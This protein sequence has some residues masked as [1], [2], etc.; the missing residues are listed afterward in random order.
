MNTTWCCVGKNKIDGYWVLQH[1]ATGAQCRVDGR[2]DYLP[3]LQLLNREERIGDIKDELDRTTFCLKRATTTINHWE[4]IHRD[5]MAETFKLIEALEVTKAIEEGT[6]SMDAMLNRIEELKTENKELK[7]AVIEKTFDGVTKKTGNS[8]IR[9]AICVAH[10]LAERNKQDEKWGEQNHDPVYWSAILTEECGEYAEAA[11]KYDAKP[12]GGR[13][14]DDMRRE[15]IQVAAV[16]LA[17]LECCER[18][19]AQATIDALGPRA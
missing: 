14:F 13:L 12:S 19:A 17:I 11:L 1:D 2:K 15:A 3:V 5:E 8:S 18:R 10:I 7:A 6:S 9:Q 16:A 4:Q